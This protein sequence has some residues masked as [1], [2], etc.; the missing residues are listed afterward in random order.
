MMVRLHGNLQTIWAVISEPNRLKESFSFSI[1]NHPVW[2]SVP[3]G[4]QILQD[5]SWI[6]NVNPQH[7]DRLKLLILV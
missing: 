3:G 4:S 2:G 6:A 7:F 1:P 5:F